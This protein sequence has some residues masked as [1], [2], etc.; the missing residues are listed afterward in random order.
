MHDQQQQDVDV[1]GLME[2][3]WQLHSLR[4]KVRKYHVDPKTCF[5]SAKLSDQLKLRGN[6][7]LKE[8]KLDLA[9][10]SYN[11]VKETRDTTRSTL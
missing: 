3:K 10:D 2:F 4:E 1:P 7:Y 6:Q 8:K 5:K 9:L 11:E